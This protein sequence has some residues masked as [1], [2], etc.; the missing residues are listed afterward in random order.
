[1]WGG[2]AQ[3]GYFLSESVSWWPDPLELALRVA[4]VDPDTSS[5]DDFQNE[6]TF[7]ANWFF[8]GHR[9]K[10]T[11][12]IGRLILGQPDDRI[13]ENLIQFQWDVSF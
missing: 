11:F 6:I 10:L 13:V 2:Y 7:A 1:M 3:A 12:G 5:G 4:W 8:D 9:N